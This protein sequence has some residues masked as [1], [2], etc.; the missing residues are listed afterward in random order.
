MKT[1]KTN[2]EE[3]NQQFINAVKNKN[4]EEVKKLLEQDENI[5]KSTDKEGSNVFHLLAMPHYSVGLELMKIVI[6]YASEE[7]INAKNDGGSSVIHLL[8]GNYIFNQGSLGESEQQL[9]DTVIKYSTPETNSAQ[10]NKGLTP[11]KIIV[12]GYTPNKNLVECLL[13]V[14]TEEEINKTLKIAFLKGNGSN[15]SF[16]LQ[17]IEKGAKIEEV[18]VDKEGNNMLHL[19]AKQYKASKELVKLAF[20]NSTEETISAKNHEGQTP[21]AIA[22]KNNNES[23]VLQLIEKGAKIEEVGVDKEGNNMLHLLANGRNLNEELVKI[24]FENSAEEMISAKNHEGQTPLAIAFN[25]NESFALQLVKKGAKIEEVGIDKEGNNMLHLFAKSYRPNEELVKIV[26]ENPTEEMINAKNN[27]GQTPLAIAFKGNHESFASQL[28]KKGA[29]IEEV[30]VDKEGNNMLHLLAKQYNSNVELVKIVVEK[31]TEE[32]INAKNNNGQTPLAIAFTSPMVFREYQNVALQQLALQL[33]EKGAKMEEVGVVDKEGNNMLHLLAQNT[34]ISNE[35][36]VKIVVENSTEEMI[37]AKNNKGLTPVDIVLSLVT[38]SSYYTSSKDFLN[39][40]LINKSDI[41]FSKNTQLKEWIMKLI[42]NGRDTKDAS[43]LV[44]FLVKND[45]IENNKELFYLFG[46]FNKNEELAH[47]FVNFLVE[48][49][50]ITENSAGFFFAQMFE[51]MSSAIVM[52]LFKFY[53]NSNQELDKNIIAKELLGK[54]GYLEFENIQEIIEITGITEIEGEFGNQ[55]VQLIQSCFKILSLEKPLQQD[56]DMGLLLTTLKIYLKN[57]NKNEKALDGLKEKI[58]E[59]Y[60]NAKDQKVIDDLEQLVDT[61]KSINNEDLFALQQEAIVS[62]IQENYKTFQ[63]LI[64][65]GFDLPGEHLSWEEFANIIKSSCTKVNDKLK[66]IANSDNPLELYKDI[67]EATIINKKEGEH[68]FTPLMKAINKSY[69]IELVKLLLESGADVNVTDNK[70]N[71]VF[72]L[73]AIER[74]YEEPLFEILKEHITKENINAKNEKGQTPLMIACDKQ[75]NEFAVNLFKVGAEVHDDYHEKM[76]SIIQTSLKGSNDVELAES[77]IDFGFDK[78]IREESFINIFQDLLNRNKHNAFSVFKYFLDKAHQELNKFSLFSSLAQ[79]YQNKVNNTSKEVLISLTTNNEMIAKKELT[80]G[81]QRLIKQALDIIDIS[82]LK[83]ENEDNIHIKSIFDCFDMLNFRLID[84]N[85][86]QD[87]LFL[88][89]ESHIKTLSK[90]SLMKLND[91]IYQTYYQQQIFVNLLKIVNI[92]NINPF[93]QKQMI[94]AFVNSKENKEIFQKF[95]KLGFK[96]PVD[97]QNLDS[98][99][100]QLNL[101]LV[102]VSKSMQEIE[103]MYNEMSLN[104]HLGLYEYFIKLTFKESFGEKCLQKLDQIFENNC[105]SILKENLVQL[106]QILTPQVQHFINENNRFNEEKIFMHKLK[107]KSI[108]MLIE[109]ISDI[110]LEN[111]QG[112]VGLIKSIIEKIKEEAKKSPAIAVDILKLSIM[113][114]ELESSTSDGKVIEIYEKEEDKVITENVR[115]IDINDF[116]LS[117]FYFDEEDIYKKEKDIKTVPVIEENLYENEE[118][119]FTLF[120]YSEEDS[121]EVENIGDNGKDDLD[122]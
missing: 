108:K 39:N 14:S 112:D 109:E 87:L 44:K 47:D 118:G 19:L 22:F 83:P 31:S 97:E 45:L 62:Y 54:L 93:I 24:V 46:K 32:M 38:S 26:F 101:S 6:N 107:N 91:S 12:N 50:F 37:N 96:C 94:C 111:I 74:S 9:V 70:G 77:F 43:N 16:L 79:K 21:L 57:L 11:F 13:K 48:K 51:K 105:E 34:Q 89:L 7:L 82:G 40:L 99:F 42:E 60:T 121:N 63:K 18:G 56:T 33:I 61:F 76:A 103:V 58:L 117:D 80:Q 59:I 20:K 69:H 104:C 88:V 68:G 5:I 65:L 30:G 3:V 115:V 2:N 85:I 23:F 100:E 49:E 55:H 81:D 122:D 72:H 119:K 86:N 120:D 15:S 53:L 27:N 35:E 71:N 41:I 28:V 29:K 113:N 98:F 106:L 25:N 52:D 114:A 110:D 95:V 75:E 17:L 78:E 84:P 36:L 102:L 67:I 90:E 66:F 64:P 8:S 116:D 73:T 1:K 10:N 4:V 92:S